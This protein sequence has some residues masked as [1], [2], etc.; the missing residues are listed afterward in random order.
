MTTIIAEAVRGSFVAGPFPI[1]AGAPRTFGVRMISTT[2]WDTPGITW[3]MEQEWSTDGGATWHS[4]SP[5]T[6]QSA[7]PAGKDGSNRPA[8]GVSWD[9]TAMS[10]RVTF[11]CSQPFSWGLGVI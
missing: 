10:L 5:D 2:D 7:G 11:T 4:K 3:T 1:S 8:A 6:F 9:G